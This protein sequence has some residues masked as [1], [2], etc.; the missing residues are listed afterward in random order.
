MLIELHANGACARGSVWVVE[1]RVRWRTAAP[2]RK[3]PT[4]RARAQLARKQWPGRS[5]AR[6]L[7]C[8]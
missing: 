7:P 3:R 2:S 8:P 4:A 6:A 5:L 1:G